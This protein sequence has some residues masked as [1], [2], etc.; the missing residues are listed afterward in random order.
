VT[1]SSELGFAALE[2]GKVKGQECCRAQFGIVL[3]ALFVKNPGMEQS[4]VR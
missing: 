1:Y 4:V 2:S 3:K